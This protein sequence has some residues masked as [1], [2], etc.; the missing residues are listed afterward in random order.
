MKLTFHN[1][2][3]HYNQRPFTLIIN[4]RQTCCPIK[5]LLDYLAL[6]GHQVGAIFVT[7]T[8]APVTRDVS[9]SQLSEAI[10]LCGLDPSQYKGHSFWI[11]TA[12][13]AAEQGMSDLQI[14]IVSHSKS[15]AFQKY[16][17]IQTMSA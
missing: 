5:L 13:H 17:R 6:C 1:F 8:G 7:Q 11:G 10:R 12:S 2:K 16:I 3:H 15:N 9:T 14:H 4:R